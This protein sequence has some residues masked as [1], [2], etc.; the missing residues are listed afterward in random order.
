MSQTVASTHIVTFPRI[1]VPMQPI[2]AHMAQVFKIFF[3][4]TEVESALLVQ[5]VEQFT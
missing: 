5:Y 4:L 2:S 3:Y 1:N